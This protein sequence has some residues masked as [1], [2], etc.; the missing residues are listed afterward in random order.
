MRTKYNKFREITTVQE[1]HI[2]VYISNLISRDPT[3][4][5]LYRIIIYHSGSVKQSIYHGYIY[6]DL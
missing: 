4:S 2:I 6:H 1:G 5:T 3:R